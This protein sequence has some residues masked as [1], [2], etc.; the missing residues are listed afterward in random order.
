MAFVSCATFLDWYFTSEEVIVEACDATMY[1]PE[2]NLLWALMEIYSPYNYLSPELVEELRT[3]FYKGEDMTNN[4][5]YQWLEQQMKEE[6]FIMETYT[7]AEVAKMLKITVSRFY[8]I[9]GEVKD[10]LPAKYYLR[11]G[12]SGNYR[13]YGDTLREFLE[14]LDTYRFGDSG[15]KKGGKNESQD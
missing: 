6:G 7:A 2:F 10:I 4:E 1:G 14:W 5:D 15:K 3:R 11:I 13:F 8:D 12:G 9:L